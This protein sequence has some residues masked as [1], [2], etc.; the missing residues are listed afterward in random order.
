[1]AINEIFER[2]FRQFRK[3][4]YA[5]N[6]FKIFDWKYLFYSFLIIVLFSIFLIVSQL[7]DKKNQKEQENFSEIIKSKEFSTLE[8]FFLS[9]I[10]NPYVE[11]KYLI[12]NNDSIEKILKKMSIKQKDITTISKKLKEKKLTNIYAGKKLS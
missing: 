10:N 7:F 3:L 11:I 4:S 6:N 2:F 9:K 12:Q 5:N 1:M 8:N